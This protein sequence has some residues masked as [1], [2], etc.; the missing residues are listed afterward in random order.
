MRSGDFG[1]EL[2]CFKILKIIALPSVYYDQYD[3]DYGQ[4]DTG[5]YR[6]IDDNIKIV[7]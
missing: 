5:K 3:H 2:L 4:W 7:P 1:P 6:Y